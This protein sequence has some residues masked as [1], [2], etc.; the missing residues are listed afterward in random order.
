MAVIHSYGAFVAYKQNDFLNVVKGEAPQSQSPSEQPIRMPQGHGICEP[1]I[2]GSRHLLTSMPLNQ[3][4]YMSCAVQ[5]LINGRA[6]H[7]GI[8]PSASNSS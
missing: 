2:S 4:I 7:R 3:S 6:N 8:L 5:S 1:R